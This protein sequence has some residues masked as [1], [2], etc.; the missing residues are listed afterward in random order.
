M[1]LK[2]A[3]Y[4][5]IRYACMNFHYSKAV[6]LSQCAYSV[7]N[8]KNDWCGVI[9]Y[10]IGANN[11][12]AKPFGLNQGQV[13]ELVRVAL[14]GLQENTSKALSISIKL[15]KKDNPLLKLIIS[16][17]DPFQNHVGII[18]QATNWIYI[19]KMGSQPDEYIYQNKRFH[20][21]SFRKQFGSHT[22][23][24]NKGLVIVKGSDKHKYCYP[25]CEEIM[26]KCQSLKEKYPKKCDNSITA[27][28]AG[29]QPAEDGQHDLI[30]QNDIPLT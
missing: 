4:K 10:S 21:R 7:F 19:G 12:I 3:S 18:Y 25:L 24:I 29:V 14:N 17:A 27:N 15:L 13:C 22:K 23:Y 11:S 9:I 6:P 5:A 28:A 26:I 16:Y 8:S 1:I 20:G 2:K 30:A